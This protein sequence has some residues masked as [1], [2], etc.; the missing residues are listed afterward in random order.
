[1][2]IGARLTLAGDVTGDAFDRSQI[3]LGVETGVVLGLTIGLLLVRIGDRREAD[4]F[5]GD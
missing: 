2:T 5:E 1:M 4:E 3:E